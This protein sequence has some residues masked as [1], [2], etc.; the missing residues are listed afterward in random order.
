MQTDRVR[1]R[2][3]A[4]C[5]NDELYYQVLRI[6]ATEQLRQMTLKYPYAG[7]G[8]SFAHWAQA[9]NQQPYNSWGNGAAMRVSAAGWAAGCERDCLRLAR[10]VTDVTH[11]HPEGLRGAEAT[12]LAIYHA[13]NKA[14]KATIHDYVEKSYYRLNFST[15]EIR[16]SYQFNESCQDAVP[17]AIVAFLESN[18]FEDAIRIAISLGGDSDTLAAITGSIAEAYYGAPD[19]IANTA[20]SYLD[21][22]LLAILDSWDACYPK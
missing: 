20:R 2:E 21:E 9:E 22:S 4:G 13:R 16:P 8:S 14:S 5:G 19:D 18:D 6:N 10:A 17:Q 15:D 1:S 3:V 7:Y 12:A 11:N